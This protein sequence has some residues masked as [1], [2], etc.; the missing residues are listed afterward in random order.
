MTAMNALTVFTTETVCVVNVTRIARRA[1]REGTIAHRAQTASTSTK[2]GTSALNAT[3][4]ARH[5]KDQDIVNRAQMVII[6]EMKMI[7]NANSAIHHAQ[8]AES[9]KITMVILN[10]FAL[11]VQADIIHR[12]FMATTVLYIVKKARL[13][14]A[15]LQ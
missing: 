3:R 14:D 12:L 4:R 6:R 2:R 13:L 1:L 11:R 8:L 15:S 10:C 7:L 9:S 5:V